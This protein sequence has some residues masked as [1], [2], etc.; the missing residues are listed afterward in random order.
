MRSFLVSEYNWL[1]MPKLVV[2]SAQIEY[3]KFVNDHLNILFSQ[4]WISVNKNRDIRTKNMHMPQ[5]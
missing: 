1:F 4:N 5:L 3:L 2:I